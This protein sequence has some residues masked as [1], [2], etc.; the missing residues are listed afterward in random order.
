M[1]DWTIFEV[2][3]GEIDPRHD[4]EIDEEDPKR[5]VVI[6]LENDELERRF[7]VLNDQ[8]V[9][10][11]LISAVRAAGLGKTRI[12]AAAGGATKT[13]P[14]PHPLGCPTRVGPKPKQKG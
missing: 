10:N 4:F 11:R 8:K 5:I 9:V 13:Q 14:A 2:L 12:P 7:E 6:V 1:R 3:D